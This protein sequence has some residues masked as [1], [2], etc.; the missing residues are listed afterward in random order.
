[1]ASNHISLDSKVL[2]TQQGT[3]EYDLM[4][5]KWTDYSEHK[6]LEVEEQMFL[7]SIPIHWKYYSD[8]DLNNS[9]QSQH[10]FSIIH[11]NSTSMDSNFNAIKEYLQ[12]LWHPFSIIAI[13][14]T[15]FNEDKAIDLKLND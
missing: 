8:N 1:M 15:C 13:S 10:N 4:E 11:F 6:S 12:Q 3:V 5:V 7:S 14:E 9:L 2:G